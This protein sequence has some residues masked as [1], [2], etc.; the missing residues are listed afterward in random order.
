M[1]SLVK[2]VAILVALLSITP[3]IESKCSGRGRGRHHRS[4]GRY[5]HCRSSWRPAFYAG[6]YDPY[7]Y[8]YG[9]GYPYGYAP[10]VYEP[11]GCSFGFNFC[12]G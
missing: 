4:S 2:L 7:A 3:F 11:V 8:E 10:Y 5:G 6:Y 9:Y 1:K 12:L